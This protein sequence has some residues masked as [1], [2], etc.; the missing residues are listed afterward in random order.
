MSHPKP[1]IT[2]YEAEKFSV[3]TGQ[4]E[5]TGIIATREAIERTQVAGLRPIWASGR[6]VDASEVNEDGVLKLP[7]RQ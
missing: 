4:F 6:V 1:P 2:V 5:P 3:N 7:V